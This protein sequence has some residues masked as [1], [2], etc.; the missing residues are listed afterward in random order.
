[1]LANRVAL[2]TGSTSGIGLGI[3]RVLA[4]QGA[5]LVIN[6]LDG[7]E[8]VDKIKRELNATYGTQVTFSNADMSSAT[9]IEEMMSLSPRIDI[10]V[11]NAGIQHVS[12]VET[13]PLERWQAIM[14]INLTSN[15]L[16]TQAALP[17]MRKQGWGRVINVA[18]VQGRVGSIHKA[19]YVAAKHGVLGLTRVVA[20][21]SAGSGITCNAICPGWVKTP[22]VE[23]QIAARAEANGTSI[24][25]ETQALLMEK[26]PSGQFATP[27]DIG[28]LASFLCSDAASNIT[29]EDFA[30]DG[31]WTAR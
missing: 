21:E 5:N 25:A 10:L 26:Q 30:V 19:A 23:Q 9:Q 8:V 15:F 17:E 7:P 24:E 14:D 6:G 3:A 13:F 22:L 27:E 12:P 31:G 28:G 2:V 20:L 4:S 11:N 18:S 1:M 29:G 16:T